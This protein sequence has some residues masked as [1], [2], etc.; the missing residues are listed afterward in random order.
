MYQLSIYP[1]SFYLLYIYPLSIYLLV[2]VCTH[3]SI[4]YLCIYVSFLSHNRLS[5]LH[6]A[7]L[8]LSPDA[9]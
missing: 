7:T 6:F 2:N 4:T 1:L 8:F 9:S 3:V 5:A